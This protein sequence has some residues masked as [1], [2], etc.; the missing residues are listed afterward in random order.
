[1]AQVRM[2][3]CGALGA[4]ALL[5]GCGIETPLVPSAST[6]SAAP[7]PSTSTS[8]VAVDETKP[9]Q[10]SLDQRLRDSAWNSDTEAAS[11]L[12]AQGANVN[13]KDSTG[14]SAYLIAASQADLPYLRLVL[15][16]GAELDA[17]DSW[18]GTAL[19]RAAERGN[20]LVA[21]ALL[22]AGIDAQRFNTLGYQAVHEAVWLGRDT[23]E[24]V[25]LVRVLSASGVALETS[26]E[27]EKLTPLEM[28][29]SRGFTRL[30][31]TLTKQLESPENT[32]PDE[33]LLAALDQDDADAAAAAIRAGANL[34]I[35]DEHGR[36]PLL[37]A[38]QDD[39]G[40]TLRLLLA[41][42][43]NPATRGPEGITGLMAAADEGDA[44]VVELLLSFQQPAPDA[45]DDQGR[46][47]LMHA[48]LG[49]DG[50]DRYQRVARELLK[51]G[52]DPAMRDTQ[53]RTA[54]DLA[55]EAGHDTLVEILSPGD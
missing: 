32:P 36:S 41:L 42:G 8:P 33:A 16:A 34:E 40:A 7:T 12:I 43:A 50:G 9:S 1:M 37:V 39:R 23:D 21:G 54:A 35:A 22:R 48:V 47:A 25:D 13:A 30:T 38:L 10:E 14:Q 27:I 44:E 5:V 20:Y 28:A 18:G 3:R 45:Q 24:Y 2:L 17:L 4:L 6:T 46:T 19:T 29:K 26:S 53:G 31:E 55:S 51:A 49:G 11:A 15:N 52:A